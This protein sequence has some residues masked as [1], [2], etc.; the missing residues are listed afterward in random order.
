MTSLL[1]SNQ[2]HAGDFKEWS[3]LPR[4]TKNRHAV[5]HDG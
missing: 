3:A 1:G 2:E 5:K 4:E